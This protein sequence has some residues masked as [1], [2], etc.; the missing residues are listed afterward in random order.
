MV[1]RAVTSAVSGKC[2]CKAV[3]KKLEKEC[4]CIQRMN[5]YICITESLCCASE[6]NTALLVKYTPVFMFIK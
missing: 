5:T 3:N 4:I 1:R 2:C 6:N